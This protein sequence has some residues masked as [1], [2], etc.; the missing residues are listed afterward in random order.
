MKTA[1]RTIICAAIAILSAVSCQKSVESVNPVDPAN[2]SEGERETIDI[3]IS[4]LMGEYTQK[5][6]VKSSLVNTVRVAWAAGDVVYVFD[7]TKYLGKLTATLDKKADGQTD[8]DRYAKLSGTISAP[9]TTPRTLSLVHSS[10]MMEPAAGSDISELSIDMSAQSTATVPFVAYATMNYTGE[11]IS[12]V[13]VPFQFATSVIKVNCTGLKPNTAITSAAL[14]NVNTICKLTLSGDKA[15]VVSGGTNGTIT[16]TGDSYFAADKVNS[17][18]VAVFQIAVPKLETASEARVLTIAQGSDKFK[19]KNFSTKSLSAAISVN[20]VCQLVS[21]TALPGKFSVQDGE[22][23]PIKQ[24]FFSPGNLYA[25]KENGSWGWRFYE[26]QYQYNSYPT[27]EGSRIAGSSDIEI[28][29]FT[30]GY[31]ESSSLNPVS[32]SYPYSHPGQYEKLLYDRSYSVGG[33]DW[34]VAYCESNGIPVGG[35]RTL[36]IKEWQYLLNARTMTNGGARYSLNIEY[37]GRKGVVLYPDDYIGDE[38]S[39][40]T[41]YTDADFP[42]DCVFLPAAGRREGANVDC[43]GVEGY[44]WTS[45]S[46]YNEMAFDVSFYSSRIDVGEEIYRSFGYSVRLATDN[47]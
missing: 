31:S 25:K 11:T 30:W 24:I 4:G 6:G 37:G 17:E 8:E 45:S 42:D 44:Y 32:T 19:Y 12:N 3:S 39:A 2:S 33:D 7:G 38:L 36:S 41:Q 1:I 26:K 34:G 18:G 20:T 35:W 5:D 9:A 10:L 40:D 15:P 13:V 47:K 16:R 23:E 28:D 22:G 46:V 27:T 21:S 29:H 43:V 14:S